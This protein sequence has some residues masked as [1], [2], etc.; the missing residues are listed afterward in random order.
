MHLVRWCWN[1]ID[2]R[3]LYRLSVNNCI[4]ISFKEH[5]AVI[6]VAMGGWVAEK[7]SMSRL[8]SE[9][10]LLNISF[11]VYG[12]NNVLSSASSNMIIAIQTVSTMVKIC[13]A[14]FRNSGLCIWFFSNRVFP[15]VIQNFMITGLKELVKNIKRRWL[16]RFVSKV[17]GELSS[18]SGYW[19]LLLVTDLRS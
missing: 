8:F 7:I 6:N 12:C 19:V 5:L 4:S 1:V 15:S 14:H 2:K 11:L 18:G 16:K 17:Q 9:D 3:I 10:P 13:V